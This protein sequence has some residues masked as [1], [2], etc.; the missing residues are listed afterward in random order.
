MADIVL[1]FHNMEKFWGSLSGIEW[2]PLVE[3][4]VAR[5][6]MIWAG[7][8]EDS[9]YGRHLRKPSVGGKNRV[10]IAEE[11][12]LDRLLCASSV[13]SQKILLGECVEDS[14]D[15]DQAGVP[16]SDDKS[17]AELRMVGSAAR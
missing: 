1:S 7:R 4:V 8:V 17:S 6:V 3:I 2:N 15:R 14:Q 9:A 5:A 16:D 11:I 10:L 12:N 13:H